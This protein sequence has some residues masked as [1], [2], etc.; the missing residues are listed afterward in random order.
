MR[1]S[2]MF[3]RNCELEAMGYKL[4]DAGRAFQI[5]HIPVGVVVGEGVGADDSGDGVASDSGDLASAAAVKGYPV[6]IVDSLRAVSGPS[7]SPGFS[8]TFRT[9]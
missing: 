1:Q 5:K 3:R 8:P 6:G 2:I 7:Q 9:E 4:R